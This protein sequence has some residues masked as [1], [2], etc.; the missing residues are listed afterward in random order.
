MA[1]ITDKE[2]KIVWVTEADTKSDASI[3]TDSTTTGN[4]D[5]F[6]IVPP[7]MNT[8]GEYETYGYIMR[9]GVKVVEGIA[10]DA[11]QELI[12][13]VDTKYTK[14]STGIPTGDIAKGAITADKI[15]DGV[16]PDTSKFALVT[17]LNWL[18]QDVQD[19][20]QLIW[21]ELGFYLKNAT[22]EIT[23]QADFDAFIEPNKVKYATFRGGSGYGNWDTSGVISGDGI[24]ISIGSEVSGFGVQIVY[25]QESNYCAMR[26]MDDRVWL[27]W[28]K[29]AFGED[30]SDYLPLEGGTMRG[31][32]AVPA[33]LSAF[34]DAKYTQC[35]IVIVPVI[36]A[37]DLSMSNGSDYDAFFKQLVK[38]ICANYADTYNTIFIGVGVPNYCVMYNIYIAGTTQLDSNGLPNECVGYVKSNDGNLM[39]FSYHNGTYKFAYED[40]Y[41]LSGTLSNLL[42]A[43]MDVGT[44]NYTSVFGINNSY[45][46]FVVSEYDDTADE[47]VEIFNSETAA[48]WA[49]D[50]IAKGEW[51][52]LCNCSAGRT[53]KV[54][55]SVKN[56]GSY[57]IYALALGLKTSGVNVEY[58][59]SNGQT[60]TIR[61]WSEW[62]SANFF[63][64]S[65][66]RT[67]EYLINT[68]NVNTPITICGFRVVTNT[69][70]PIFVG[71]ANEAHLADKA[72]TADSATTADKASTANTLQG[73][74]YRNILER[75]QSGDS[76]CSTAGWY[77][78]GECIRSNTDGN[79]F[80]LSITRQYA[81][82]ASESYLFAI[83]ETY[84]G[85]YS[86]TQIAGVYNEQLIKRIR[87]DYVNWTKSY[88]DFYYEY[89]GGNT[90]YWT[91]IGSATSYTTAQSNPTLQ[92]T[93]YEFNIGEG[94]ISNKGFSAPKFVTDG[95]TSAQFVRGDGTLGSLS[96]MNNTQEVVS[97]SPSGQ[98]T[99]N[100]EPSKVYNIN[101]YN[102]DRLEFNLFN[103]SEGIV[104]EYTIM[105]FGIAA[106]S[107]LF[108]IIANT[109][110]GNIGQIFFEEGKELYPD[111]QGN[112]CFST[113]CHALLKIKSFDGGENYFITWERYDI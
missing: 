59:C 72:T 110:S 103:A 82:I 99:I 106:D 79:T 38:W 30:L 84:G 112:Y 11:M 23:T 34:A 13:E 98:Q 62:S 83:A 24:V 2:L 108:Y 87:V 28:S 61:S 15:A 49:K 20:D 45:H 73:Y 48:E 96:E 76:W 10:V 4:T 68:T 25:D 105:L 50:V 66:P 86:I 22:Q 81:S 113:D 14:P 101:C 26:A 12:E 100:I 75:H 71:K 19:K 69:S 37:A 42:S 17:D 44:Y 78:I 60:G 32:L 92:G 89:D 94:C 77:R 46:T 1:T 55:I 40:G 16:I 8:E 74:T 36:R 9:N 51:S 90:I 65:P 39:S 6:Y 33:L 57:Y 43:Q 5:A 102:A 31:D 56:N 109:A 53:I 64:Q 97:I 70:E 88:I 58:E 63:H 52:N 107:P 21:G 104:R 91:T 35:G 41:L 67:I 111:P 93:T 47:W 80:L 18:E 95:G 54:T 29:F 7:R 27:K 3:I 85:K